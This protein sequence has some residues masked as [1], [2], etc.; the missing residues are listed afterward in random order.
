MY[1]LALDKW[2]PKFRRYQAFEFTK[3][4]KEARDLYIDHKDFMILRVKMHVE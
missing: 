3:F 2:M 1:Y 4:L